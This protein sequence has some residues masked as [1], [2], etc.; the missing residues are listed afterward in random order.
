M[1]DK[2]LRNFSDVF[3]IFFYPRKVREDVVLSRKNVTAALVVVI[4]YNL[5]NVFLGYMYVLRM[6]FFWRV[7]FLFLAT[8][9][10]FPLNTEIEVENFKN[11]RQQRTKVVCFRAFLFKEEYL[12]KSCYFGSLFI[13][14]C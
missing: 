11:T 9:L 12:Q 8:L 5:K 4:Y 3:L 14:F 13:L 10:C 1:W 6:F 2:H 7:V